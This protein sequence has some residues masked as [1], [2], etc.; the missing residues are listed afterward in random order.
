MSPRTPI[1]E[2][3]G[4]RP[5]SCHAPKVRASAGSLS[6]SS[7]VRR[8]QRVRSHTHLPAAL[9]R[10][11]DRPIP[12]DII[13]FPRS[14]SPDLCEASSALVPYYVHDYS[15]SAVLPAVRFL[16]Q[17]QATAST[18]LP[19]KAEVALPQAS[20]GH[21][22]AGMGRTDR[23]PCPVG[24]RRQDFC[25]PTTPAI[26]HRPTLP[27][28]HSRAKQRPRFPQLVFPPFGAVCSHGGQRGLHRGP[29]DLSRSG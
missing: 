6:S 15:G 26:P 10:H 4:T 24:S 3:R 29:G 11:D 28:T 2:T 1:R 9:V 23:S 14:E 5:I 12:V 16:Y 13:G 7:F 18:L 20:A 25:H 27:T 22:T 8:D 19:P 21:A 17:R